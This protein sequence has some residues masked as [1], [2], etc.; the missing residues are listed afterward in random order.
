MRIRC[1]TISRIYKYSINFI[2]QLY[3]IYIFLYTFLVISLARHKQYIICR[4]SFSKFTDMLPVFTCAS[5]IG[6]LWNICL[7]VNKSFFLFYI[8]SSI[9]NH[10]RTIFIKLDDLVSIEISIS[11]C[12]F[13]DFL[14]PT[15]ILLGFDSN[16][17]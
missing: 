14:P 7:G 13:S 5:A 1:F 8:I 3:W 16:L 4:I 6:I 12:Y 2:L 15:P 10:C 17:I 11:F 9:N